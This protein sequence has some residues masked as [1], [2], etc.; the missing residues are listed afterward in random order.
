MAECHV[1]DRLSSLQLSLLVVSQHA[2]LQLYNEVKVCSFHVD[3]LLTALRCPVFSIL[4][5]ST[6]N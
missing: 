2:R 3:M 5:T 4:F 6:T 1:S